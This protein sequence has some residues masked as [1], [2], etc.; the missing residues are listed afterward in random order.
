MSEEP[1]PQPGNNRTILV[2][3]D[4]DALRATVRRVLELD[5]RDANLVHASPPS[6]S[7]SL[8]PMNSFVPAQPS[9]AL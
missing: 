6:S 5:R 1:A 7:A 2:L 9:R 3:D 4:D 8:A